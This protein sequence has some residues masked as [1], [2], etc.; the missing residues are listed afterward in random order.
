MSFLGIDLGATFIKG[1]IL[2][3]EGQAIRNVLRRPF[4]GF[5][6]P[7]HRYKR[8]VDPEAILGS[9]R[10]LLAELLTGCA[11]C[12]GV[13][14]TGQ[15][16]GLILADSRG[17]PLSPYISWQDQ[18][19][20]IKDA[21]GATT[22]SRVEGVLTPE[23]RRQAGNELRPG[24]PI[25][26]LKSL[27]EANQL[28]TGARPCSLVDF[29][30]AALRQDEPVA[31]TTSASAHGVLNLE[32]LDWHWPVLEALGLDGLD[33]PRIVQPGQALGEFSFEG[34]PLQMFSGISDNKAALLGIGLGEDELSLNIATGSQ[35]S[36]LGQ[37]LRTGDFQTHPFPGGRWL[38]TVTH[39]PAGRSL[40]RVLALLY[41]HL[42]AEEAW[43]AVLAAVQRTPVTDLRVN[44]S[45]FESATGNRGS[46]EN[47][48]EGNFDP[49]HIFR[50]AFECMAA[51]YES[52]GARIWPERRWNRL[53]FSG[54][55]ASKLEPLRAAIQQRLGLEYR[56]CESREDALEGLLQLAG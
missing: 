9:V 38:F 4:P 2:D 21:D 36:R 17:R 11:D 18:R 40:N 27:T 51:N 35:V 16:Y 53:A 37:Q 49:G 26:L 47:I 5:E 19:P 43:T 28:P 24:S 50:A 20:Q 45:F 42:A 15:M 7:A 48:H 6:Q 32:T 55:L 10:S 33:W 30:V 1:A 54:G 56:L 22:W 13:F 44:L 3:V 25:C 52:A 12:R 39:L 46:L 29:V 14:V 34:S 8:E 23:W 41:P 31:D